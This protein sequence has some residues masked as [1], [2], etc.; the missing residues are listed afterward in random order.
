MSYPNWFE[1]G[2]EWYFR[3]HL[4]FFVN[5]KASFLQIGAYTG[6]ASLWML[7]NILTHD[8]SKLTDVDTWQGSDEAIHKSFDWKSVE[9]TY[10]DK[11]HEY[12]QADKLIKFKGTSDD[13]FTASGFLHREYDFVYVDGD[14]TSLGVLKDGINAMQVV[15]P[16][17]VVAFDDYTW[18]SGRGPTFDPGPAID[19]LIVA[20]ADKFEVIDKGVQVW[21]RRK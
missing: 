3:K 10:D 1:M 19:A 6:D 16:G 17:G 11:T 14:H 8:H 4:P 12:S 9:Q 5:K 7:E 13:F 2:A 15:A 18:R 21:L 20:F